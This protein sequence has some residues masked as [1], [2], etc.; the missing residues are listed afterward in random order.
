[1]AKLL[2]GQAAD[3][4]GKRTEALDLYRGAIEGP[5]FLGRD[6]AYRYQRAPFRGPA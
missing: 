3:L 1:M 6:A 5:S 2:A 4:A